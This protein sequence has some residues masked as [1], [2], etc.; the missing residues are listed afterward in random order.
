M[1][2][3]SSLEKCP[4]CGSKEFW[5]S[6]SRLASKI[7]EMIGFGEKKSIYSDGNF[8]KEEMFAVYRFIQHAKRRLS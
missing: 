1:P 2:K 5:M 4:T 8:S 7:L 6:K 3:I